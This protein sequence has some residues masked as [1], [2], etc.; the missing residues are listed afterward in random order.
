MLNVVKAKPT[1]DT[2][3]LVI[4]RTIA[5]LHTHYFVVFHVVGEQT[6]HTTKWAHRINFFVDHLRPHLR[7]GHESACW[8]GLH[9]FAAGH[10]TAAAHAV[11]KVKHNLAAGTPVRIT[12]DVVHLLFAASA[13]TSV[14]LNTRIEI[15]CHGRVRHI[16]RRL[17]S[18]QTL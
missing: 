10:T 15:D 17:L 8:A 13:N 7:L 14:A 4:G 1:L 12:N 16:T 18:A 3:T 5:P 6:T 11:F 9:A 2:Q